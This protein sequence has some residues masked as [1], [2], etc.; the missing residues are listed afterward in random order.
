VLRHFPFSIHSLQGQNPTASSPFCSESL[1]KMGERI[2]GGPIT[3][4]M[5]SRSKRDQTLGE[6]Q[7]GFKKAWESKRMATPG[8]LNARTPPR[9]ILP[10]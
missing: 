4:G 10:V 8:Q 2:F 6:V 5:K 3:H 9:D 7:N 1:P